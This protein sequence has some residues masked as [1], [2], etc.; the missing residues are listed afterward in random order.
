LLCLQDPKPQ[1]PDPRPQTLNQLPIMHDDKTIQRFIDLRV[2]GRTFASLATELKVSKPT[3]IAWSREG[4]R[5]D[6]LLPG[7]SR[8][9]NGK[10]NNGASRETE[11]L[12]FC[13]RQKTI[14][15]SLLTIST[16]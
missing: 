7:E 1:T 3:L 6:W 14:S 10:L 9:K 15:K 13:P 5:K 2:Q 4:V 12:P 8:T 11:F 16:E